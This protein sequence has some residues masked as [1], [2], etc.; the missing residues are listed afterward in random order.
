MWNKNGGNFLAAN[1]NRFH[2][3]TAD[4]VF[5]IAQ[6]KPEDEGV[7]RCTASNSEGQI[8]I[9]VTLT[10]Q[11]PPSFTEPMRRNKVVNEGQTA[12]LECMAEGRPKPLLTWKKDNQS[13]ELTK[14][15]F[16]AAN[17]QLLIIVKTTLSDSGKYTCEMRNTLAVAV[18]ILS[19]TYRVWT[20]ISPPGN[21]VPPQRKARWMS[22]LQLV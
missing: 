7:Y 18:T 20:T 22:P 19:S 5:F 10:V 16:H 4:D 1:E 12:V 21:R 8:S 6:V 2:V 9:N 13:L 11:Q 17:N 14:R 3:M 15:H